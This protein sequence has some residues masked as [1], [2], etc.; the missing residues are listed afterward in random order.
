[1]VCKATWSSCWRINRCGSDGSVNFS[2]GTNSTIRYIWVEINWS[3]NWKRISFYGADDLF[4][5]TGKTS[6]CWL[7]SLWSAGRL[8]TSSEV[9]NECGQTG[10]SYFKRGKCAQ[11]FLV[12]KWIVF[13]LWFVNEWI[14]WN[15][16]YSRSSRPWHGSSFGFL[17]SSSS[18]SI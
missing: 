2:T 4:I 16:L 7:A 15:A 10:I 18:W 1:M 17:S 3:C 11:R 5:F 12:L 9:R 14:N 6:R 13:R 8:A